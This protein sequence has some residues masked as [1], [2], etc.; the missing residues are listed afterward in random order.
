MNKYRVTVEAVIRKTYEVEAEDE[1][2]AQNQANEMFT[3]EPES[4]EYY[5]QQA[6]DVELAE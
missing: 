3:T 4:D 6:I 5:G 1:Q 2:A